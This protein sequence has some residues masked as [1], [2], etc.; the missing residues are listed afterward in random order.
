MRRLLNAIDRVNEYVSNFISLL[1]APM[2]VISVYE[3]AMRYVFDRPT[4]WV[5]DVNT[6][7]FALLVVFG[8]GN[9]LLQG[10]HVVM[11]VLVSRF[12]D[13]TRRILNIF[14]Y[15]LFVVVVGVLAWQTGV[16]AWRSVQVG[17]TTSTILDMPVYPVK[18]GVFF[19]VALLWLEGISVLGKNLVPHRDQGKAT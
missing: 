5:W 18:V 15:S 13:R 14:C 10:G 12:T 2:A 1:Y 11:D 17:E 16:F 3:V 6:H 8:A 4:I 19:G 9:T 7:L